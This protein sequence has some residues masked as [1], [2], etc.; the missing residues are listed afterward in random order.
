MAMHSPHRCTVI[1]LAASA[2]L[3][4]GRLLCMMLLAAGM[5][6]ASSV[7]GLYSSYDWNVSSGAAIM[8]TCTACFGA[9]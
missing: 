8:L 2:A 4:T 1:I 9:A 5:A 7:V 3:L 6:V